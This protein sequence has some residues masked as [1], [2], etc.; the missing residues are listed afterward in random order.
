MEPLSGKNL[1]HP[2]LPLKS[3]LKNDVPISYNVKW[4]KRIDSVK[5][6]RIFNENC[7]PSF[8]TKNWW[9]FTNIHVSNAKHMLNDLIWVSWTHFS[10]YSVCQIKMIVWF[11]R[12]KKGNESPLKELQNGTNPIV[13]AQFVWQQH[14]KQWKGVK[15]LIA[16]R[17]KNLSCQKQHVNFNVALRLNE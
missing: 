1:V 2:H 14:W 7:G 9:I 10:H 17:K 13:L 4:K 12:T 3:I 6:C 5:L 8:Y 15:S 16:K 11:L